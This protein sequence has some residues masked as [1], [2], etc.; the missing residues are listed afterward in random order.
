MNSPANCVFVCGVTGNQGGALARKLIQLGWT[1]HATARDLEAPRASALAALGVKLTQGDWDNKEALRAG[2]VGCDKIFINLVSTLE[3][4][5]RE[6]R[7]AAT[8][9]TIAK[10]VGVRQAIV[11]T[12]LGVSR[13]SL[14]DIQI[15]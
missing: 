6:R 12:S 10:S 14:S 3:D 8:I 13:K 1:V 7:Q 4:F 11:S 15:F 2:L 5:D 9:A